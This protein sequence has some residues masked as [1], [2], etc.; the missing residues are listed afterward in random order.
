MTEIV[1]KLDPIKFKE[2]TLKLTYYAGVEDYKN[3]VG[4][5]HVDVDFI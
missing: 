4:L 5:I 3:T 1:V 2:V